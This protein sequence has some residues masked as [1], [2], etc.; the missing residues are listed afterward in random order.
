M[1]VAEA[2]RCTHYWVI[3]TPAGASS[4][5]RCRLCGQEREFQ[6]FLAD[7]RWDDT[8]APEA[9]ILARPTQGLSETTEEE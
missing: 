3:E 4:R 8:R 7:A 1:A 9:P 5:G 2:P 6:N